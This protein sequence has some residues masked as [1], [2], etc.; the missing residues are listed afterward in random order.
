M[1]VDHHFI[2]EN[3]DQMIIKFPLVQLKDLLAD[4]L[5]KVVLKNTLI[6]WLTS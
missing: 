3:L 5:T 6:A 4:V 2:K 1:K